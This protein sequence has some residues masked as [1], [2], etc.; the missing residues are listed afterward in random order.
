[1]GGFRPFRRR[2]WRPSFT[3]DRVHDVDAA[4]LVR[5]PDGRLPGRARRVLHRCVRIRRVHVLVQIVGSVVFLDPVRH[6]GLP[7]IGHGGRWI[8]EA[9]YLV[10][11]GGRVQLTLLRDLPLFPHHSLK[12]LQEIAGRRLIGRGELLRRREPRAV[13]PSR[14]HRLPL[15][16]S[17]APWFLLRR[18]IERDLLPCP[19]LRLGRRRWFLNGHPAL[20]LGTG[21]S[22][23]LR[24]IRRSRVVA[25]A[26]LHGTSSH[27]VHVRV[28]PDRLDRVVVMNQRM[29]PVHRV[30]LRVLPRQTGTGDVLLLLLL[31]LGS[32]SWRR[33]EWRG[34]GKVW[35]ARSV[36]RRAGARAWVG[37]VR[38]GH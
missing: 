14:R 1:M 34:R 5:E 12:I 16:Q 25:R 26:L 17:W 23:Q 22:F 3:G 20:W 11:S 19:R 35:R 8:A 24:E 15:R 7:V 21:G 13:G 29:G 4:V 28:W 2:R 32:V 27:R 10:R 18:E 33:N 36:G 31:L 9:E 37:T 6:V 38:R 30:C